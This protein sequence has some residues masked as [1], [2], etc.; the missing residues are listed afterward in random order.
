MDNKFDSKLNRRY[1]NP[2]GPLICL[3]LPCRSKDI[4]HWP[5]YWEECPEE[6]KQKLRAAR[7]SE[8]AKDGPSRSNRLQ[9][10]AKKKQDKEN[11][12]SAGA[13]GRLGDVN[14]NL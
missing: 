10:I 5:E 6:E 4:T 1:K 2:K 7:E 8:K 13:V 14:H 11:K 9:T 3:Y 12:Q